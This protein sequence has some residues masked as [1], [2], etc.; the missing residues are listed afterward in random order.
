[1]HSCLLLRRVRC[2]L[3]LRKFEV[4]GMLTTRS[5]GA[6]QVHSYQFSRAPRSGQ[7]PAQ[8]ITRHTFAKGPCGNRREDQRLGG[9]DLAWGNEGR[10]ETQNDV[11][12]CLSEPT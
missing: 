3:R 8:E 2:S 4:E 12:A 9:T 6:S 1:M 10:S 5:P 11:D 7:H